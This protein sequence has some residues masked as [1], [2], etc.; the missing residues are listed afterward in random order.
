MSEYEKELYK[1]ALPELKAS[2]QKGVEFVAK[3]AASL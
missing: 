3:Q 2:I 1:N